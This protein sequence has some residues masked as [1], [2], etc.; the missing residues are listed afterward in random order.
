MPK[1]KA[2]K[3]VT[4]A[5]KQ[6]HTRPL[7][8]RLQGIREMILEGNYPNC[9]TIATK[10]EVSVRTV[11]RDID[12]LRN[13]ED[14]IYYDSV[15][16]GYRYSPVEEDGRGYRTLRDLKSLAAT[17]PKE[18]ERIMPADGLSESA[19]LQQVVY[20]TLSKIESWQKAADGTEGMEETHRL[21][22]LFKSCLIFEYLVGRS[23][24]ILCSMP[25]G[26]V[27]VDDLKTSVILEEQINVLK[28]LS[29]ELTPAIQARIPTYM[30]TKQLLLAKDDRLIRHLGELRKKAISQ[31]QDGLKLRQKP[32][33]LP[34][35]LRGLK[36]FCESHFI[37]CVA[38][39][40][41]QMK[42]LAEDPEF[43][44]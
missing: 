40:E 15:K 4:K 35:F 37:V 19:S 18:R 8:L 23:V 41:P 39:I 20:Y 16:I 30:D 24:A 9:R 3:P 14:P 22:M 36:E 26:E 43:T 13:R 42:Q 27:R 2:T 12:F 21:G 29:Q 1:T 44:G 28:Q 6:I 31:D 33:L 34:D 17:P 11:L 10:L 7:V 32:S 5:T 25:A 38:A